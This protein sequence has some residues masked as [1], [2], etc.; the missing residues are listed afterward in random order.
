MT[1]AER[2]NYWAAKI[3]DAI[4][5]YRELTGEWDE[6]S[7][8]T[9]AIARAVAPAAMR[10]ADGEQDELDSMRGS[11]RVYET[12]EDMFSD[13]DEFAQSE[14]KALEAENIRLQKLAEHRLSVIQHWEEEY[15]HA[16]ERITDLKDDVIFWASMYR[17]VSEDG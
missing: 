2:F 6:I 10:L 11:G 4:Y 14:V 3:E 5:E 17:K 7:G 15:E 1:Y 8:I 9:Q 13:L 16:Q 12:P